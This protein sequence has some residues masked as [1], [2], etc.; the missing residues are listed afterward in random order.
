VAAGYGYPPS[1]PTQ[2]PPQP[3]YGYPQQQPGY[4]YPQTMQPPQTQPPH[5]GYGYPAPQQ[6][7]G[8]PG[9]PPQ[10]AP[11]A[12]PDFALPPQGPQFQPR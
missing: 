8:V 3:G 12:D 7:P 5:P 6:A 1:Q 10:P 2:Q 9:V 4:G 11:V